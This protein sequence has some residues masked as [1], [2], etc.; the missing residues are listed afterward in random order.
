[1][2]DSE[3]DILRNALRAHVNA[4]AV[5]IGP[6]TPSSRASLVRAAN[7]IHGVFDDAGFSVQE[8]NYEYFDQRVT[9]VPAMDPATT[10]ASAYCVVGAHYDTVPGTPGADDNASAVAVMLE[11]A[12][13]I[14]HHRLEAPRPLCGLYP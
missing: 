1:V 3:L 6:R 4:L 13:R 10:G 7:Y 8:Q 11:L 5:D 9:N 14:R 2:T 12:R